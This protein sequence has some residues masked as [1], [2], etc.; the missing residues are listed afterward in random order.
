[1]FG[2]Y[3]CIG[4]SLESAQCTTGYGPV[5]AQNFG[6]DRA[7]ARAGLWGHGPGPVWAWVLWARGDHWR[8]TPTARS[9]AAP[10]RRGEA[11]APDACAAHRRAWW[12]IPVENVMRKLD[13]GSVTDVAICWRSLVLV[14]DPMCCYTVLG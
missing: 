10:D 5:W 12:S 14:F 8:T 2:L 7:R 9:T 6:I 3:Y 4:Q 13:V 1:M 11:P